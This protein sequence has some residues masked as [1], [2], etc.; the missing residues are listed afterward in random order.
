MVRQLY[1]LLDFKEFMYDPTI[2]IDDLVD[3]RNEPLSKIVYYWRRHGLMPFV[4]ASKHIELSF[5]QL[6]WVHILDSLRQFGYTTEK[7]KKVCDY[8]FKDAYDDNIPTLNAQYNK[9]YFER[10][11]RDGT[12]TDDEEQKL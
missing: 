3:Y 4:P 5:L 1:S 6:I 12:L 2:N 8:F 7:M 9:K 10:K 11:K